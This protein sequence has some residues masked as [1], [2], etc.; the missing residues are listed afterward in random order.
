MSKK[1]FTLLLVAVFALAQFSAA[2][3]LRVAGTAT[4]STTAV[5]SAVAAG[6]TIALDWT[7]SGMPAGTKEVSV[8]SRIQN[9]GAPVAYTN[10]RAVAVITGTSSASGTYLYD[11]TLPGAAN[12]DVVEFIAVIDDAVACAAVAP[13]ATDAA[14]A[15][16][17]VDSNAL[18]GF[19]AVPPYNGV[20]AVGLQPVA[21]NTFENWAIANDH[22]GF[23]PTVAYSGFGAWNQSVTGTFAPAPEG[24][25]DELLSWPYTF[26]AT[27]SGAWSFS[28]SPEDAAG[29][30]V[31]GAPVAFR[32]ALAIAPAELADCTDFP[33]TAGHADELYIRYL[34]TIGLISG[35]ADGTFGPDNTLTRAEAATLFEKANGVSDTDPGFGTPPAAGS[36]CDFSDVAATDWFAGWV[37]RACADGFMNGIGGGLFDPNNLLTRGQVVTIF[38]NISTMIPAAGSFLASGNVINWGGYG[39]VN[40]YR[41]AAFSD[42]PVGAYY[43]TPVVNAYGMGIAEGVTSTTFEP[44]SPATRGVFSMMLYR[45]L[46]NLA[47]Y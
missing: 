32:N 16:T 21:C 3:A 40:P 38:N 29:N 41:T 10:C 26:P 30:P 4:L 31:V 25:G 1:V 17:T 28:V 35:F 36:A 9:L 37:W 47:L 27:A 2:S 34:A 39:V 7:A 23:A 19:I 6:S 11:M 45:A 33:D 15:S 5:F 42:V 22:Y 24:P 20:A 14:M 8:W 44:D 18:T 12:G 43:A 13:A 46:S